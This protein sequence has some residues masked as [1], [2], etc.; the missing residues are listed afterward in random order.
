MNI[1]ELQSCIR[2]FN[3]ARKW[4]Q[5]HTPR[6]LAESISIEAAELL[7][8]F[9]WDNQFDNPLQSNELNHEIAD[10]MIYCLSLCNALGV[11]ADSIILE[12]MAINEKKYPI[13]ERE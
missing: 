12:K 11:E 13:H 3:D 9:Q 2:E 1:L 6:N 8:C 4:R 7:K 10:V 5:Y